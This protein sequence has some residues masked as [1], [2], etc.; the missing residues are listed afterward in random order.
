MKT[1]T[2]ANG[3]ALSMAPIALWS[4]G[5]MTKD[6]NGVPAGTY[7]VVITDVLG[8]VGTAS[9]TVPAATTIAAVVSKT[10]A[11]CGGSNTGSIA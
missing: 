11:A 8:C 2:S 1:G 6:L 10:D 9:A 7:T 5:A 4:N 3:A